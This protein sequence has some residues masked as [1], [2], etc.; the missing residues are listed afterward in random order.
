MVDPEEDDP[1]E[2]Y[3]REFLARKR[4]EARAWKEAEWARKMKAYQWYQR[5]CYPMLLLSI[6]LIV[7]FYLPAYHVEELPFRGWQETYEHGRNKYL[8]SFMETENYQV[9]VP[10]KIYL[11]YDFAADEKKLIQLSISPIFRTITAIGIETAS[12]FDVHPAVKGIYAYKI[13]LPYFLFVTSAFFIFRR[14]YSDWNYRL[15]I[16]PFIAL[17]ANVLAMAFA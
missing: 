15:S 6:L 1:V 17:A 11:N 8:M 4:E 16:L 7:Y 3:R 5:A 10:H 14:K 12:G 2:Q 13:P 9:A